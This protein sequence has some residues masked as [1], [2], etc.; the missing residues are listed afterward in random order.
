MAQFHVDRFYRATP[1]LIWKF[2]N[3]FE[4][5]RSERIHATILEPGDPD[6]N[7]S[8]L[9]R[10]LKINGATIREKILA[11]SPG[12]SIEYQLISGVPV[13]DYYGTIFVYPEREGTTVRWV[14]SFKSDFPWPEW[15][16]KRRAV[17]HIESILDEMAKVVQDTTDKE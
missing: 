8:G 9:I 10:E 3:D 7:N 4:A 6:H 12:E 5:S 2:L 11:I 17:R 13:H 1:E 16:I 15:L 14:V